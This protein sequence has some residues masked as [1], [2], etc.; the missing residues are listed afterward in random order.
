MQNPQ[1]QSPSL[2][3]FFALQPPLVAVAWQ[4]KLIGQPVWLHGCAAQPLASAPVALGEQNV[5]VGQVNPSVQGNVSQRPVALQ[6]WAA[7]Q[8]VAVQAATQ[9]VELMLQQGVRLDRQTSPVGQSPSTLQ[10]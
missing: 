10:S 8:D 9:V 5:P 4:T 7:G 3:H 6:R 2:E 1:S